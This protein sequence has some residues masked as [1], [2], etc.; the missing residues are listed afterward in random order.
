[1]HGF[2]FNIETD[3][4]YF[5]NIVPCGIS[6]KAVTSLSAELGRKVDIAEV[7]SLLKENFVTLFEG[8]SIEE[9]DEEGHYQV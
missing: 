6:D 1:M 2:A 5:N 7:Q 3:L 4:T 9:F 8:S